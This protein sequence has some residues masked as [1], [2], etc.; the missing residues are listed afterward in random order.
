MVIIVWAKRE[1]EL[2]EIE[3]FPSI[4]S[5]IPFSRRK[6]WPPLYFKSPA[7]FPL[8]SAVTLP[9]TAF[10]VLALIS[11]AKNRENLRKNR[12]WIVFGFFLSADTVVV[13]T[14]LRLSPF[15]P[16]SLA[17]LG[18]TFATGSP[19]REFSIFYSQNSCFIDLCGRCSSLC[20][21]EQI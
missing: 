3:R 21:T 15:R 17:R 5:S 4:I 11:N 16:S 19:L 8:R 14:P 12:T 2:I 20:H 1:R 6:T 7:P 10:C 13:S 9:P 18:T